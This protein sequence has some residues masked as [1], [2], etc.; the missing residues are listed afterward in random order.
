MSVALDRLTTP[1]IVCLGPGGV[2]KTSM[3]AAIGVALAHTGKRVVVLTID[4][5]RRLADAMGLDEQLGNEP[6]QIKGP[7]SGELWAS[8]LDPAATFE[9]VITE[10]APT[11]AQAK[12]ILTNRLFANLATSLSG[13][14]EYMATER[15]HALGNDDRFDVVVV[16]TP[17]SRH[18]FDFLDAPGRLTRFIDHP[19]YRH[20]LAPR[21]GLL[22]AVSKA[23]QLAVRTVSRIVGADLLGEVVD[24]F[25]L[26]DGMDDGFR[27]RARL[28]DQHLSGVDTAYVL[29]AS[30]R[31]QAVE[32]AE[33]IANNLTKRDRSISLLLVNRVI[34]RHFA[35]ASVL[36]DETVPPPVRQNLADLRRQIDDETRLS[37]QLGDATGGAPRCT[38]P[39][40]PKAVSD[41][42][43]LLALASHL[44]E[45]QSSS[46]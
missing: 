5:A 7:W 20:V 43:G 9:Q 14:G 23:N 22:R 21:R 12:R 41:L 3:S 4:P 25:S 40:Q 34:P 37:D 8:M 11:P 30:A 32:E 33:W 42:G 29:V 36:A 19:L 44:A 13:T 38:I 24:F 15:L 1:T 6:Q 16:D 18:A 28:V 26:F 27:D 17:P 10:Q 46:A 2:G 39:Q 35:T 31:F 45:D